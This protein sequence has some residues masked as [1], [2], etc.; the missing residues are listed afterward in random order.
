MRKH[1]LYLTCLILALFW[2]MPCQA[3]SP[4]KWQLQWM[5]TGA[6]REEVRIPIEVAD[7]PTDMAWQRTQAGNEWI[8]QREIEGWSEYQSHNDGLPILVSENKNILYSLTEITGE[9]QSAPEWFERVAGPREL[10][11]TI[12]VPGLILTST[13]DQRN[14]LL[15]S[16]SF[17]R[18]SDVGSEGVLLKVVRVDGLVM[19]IGIVAA[20]FILA[21][22][23]FYRR[24]RRAEQI[25]AETYA[26]PPKDSN[27]D[28]ENKK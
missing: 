13:A 17:A 15:S 25:I 23:I 9:V 8:Y 7:A 28:H 3:A 24:L 26:I 21:V 6:L 2:V 5:E 20:G 18:G 19:G 10:Q 22:V 4:V 11:L 27:P 12:E 14:D 16:W 1:L